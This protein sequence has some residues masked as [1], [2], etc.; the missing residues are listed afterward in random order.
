MNYVI[1]NN[2]KLFDDN[3]NLK[4]FKEVDLH[5]EDRVDAVFCEITKRILEGI[6]KEP[7]SRDKL[8]PESWLLK[9]A[10]IFIL[11]KIQRGI[12]YDENTELIEEL[13]RFFDKESFYVKVWGFNR[14]E[15]PNQ[16]DQFIF[17]YRK[18]LGFVEDLFPEKIESNNIIGELLENI[19]NK[20]L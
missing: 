17:A 19:E 15:N 11:S 20:I 4:G 7:Q 3:I 16:L 2:H 18:D 8:L 12:L 1:L 10:G 6:H 5:G 13:F 14:P 9:D